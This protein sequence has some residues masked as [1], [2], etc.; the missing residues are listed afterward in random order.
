MLGSGCNCAQ[1]FADLRGTAS[2]VHGIL[3]DK[4]ADII[5]FTLALALRPL[6]SSIAELL[7]FDRDIGFYS[8]RVICA[9]VYPLVTSPF[10]S[11]R[12]LD[13][14]PSRPSGLERKKTPGCRAIPGLF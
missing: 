11:A 8:L 14:Q 3:F 12:L 1:F 7:E 2:A 10:P 5:G 6:G 4:L 13:R 9:A